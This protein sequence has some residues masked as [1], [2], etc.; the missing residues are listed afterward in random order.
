MKTS[1]VPPFGVKCP[2]RKLRSSQTLHIL[3][4][5]RI[6]RGIDLAH[7][8]NFKGAGTVKA[9]VATALGFGSPI[10]VQQSQRQRKHNRERERHADI[11]EQ[12]LGIDKAGD[13]AVHHAGLQS[14]FV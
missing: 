9:G 1:R 5:I 12:V 4:A 8:E 6:D 11:W 13:N 14:L 7:I 10:E 2:N 3:R